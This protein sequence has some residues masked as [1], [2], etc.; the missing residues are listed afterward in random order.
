MSTQGQSIVGY[1]LAGRPEDD[2]YPTPPEATMRLME[3]E[4]FTGFV[5]EPACG[6]GSMSRVLKDFIGVVSTDLIDRGYGSCGIDFLAETRLRA[7][8]IVT[9]PPYR[10]AQKFAEHGLE[11]GV[12]KMALLLK[13][14]FLEGQSRSK[15]LA[16]SPL[17]HVWVFRKRL[18]MTRNGERVR[19]SGMIAYAWFVWENGYDES[20]K[21]G[22]L[23]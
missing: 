7:Q 16:L 17:K 21:I 5:W 6:D 4:D 20:P 23:P 22:W 14:N 15:F 9:N 18:T 8:N 2:F 11:L 12:R 10:L 19:N 3:V 13:L 1:K